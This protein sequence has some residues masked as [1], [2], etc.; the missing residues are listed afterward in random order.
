MYPTRTNYQNCHGW[1]NTILFAPRGQNRL[2]STVGPIKLRAYAVAVFFHVPITRCLDRGLREG[3]AVGA[4]MHARRVYVVTL[5]LFEYGRRPEHLGCQKSFT[6]FY[7]TIPYH[8]IPYTLLLLL[9]L[10]LCTQYCIHGR[11]LRVLRLHLPHRPYRYRLRVGAHL[12]AAGSQIKAKPLNASDI[13]GVNVAVYK[14]GRTTGGRR[15]NVAKGGQ[16]QPSNKR[17]RCSVSP[18]HSSLY[19]TTAVGISVCV[20]RAY[21]TVYS[22]LAAPNAHKC[23]AMHVYMRQVRPKQ[24]STCT[25]STASPRTHKLQL[26]GAS[27]PAVV[28]NRDRTASCLSI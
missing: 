11:R 16:T 4:C 21:C 10:R 9:Q 24:F 14:L 2:P 23:P 5:S 17:K 13:F 3:H 15:E 1:Y 20:R 25:K 19:H 26:G 8:T 12:C 18:T 22:V 7:H 27:T 28:S 6:D